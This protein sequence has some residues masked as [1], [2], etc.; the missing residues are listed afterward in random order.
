MTIVHSHVYKRVR[1]QTHK[2]QQNKDKKKWMPI[3]R[4]HIY[5]R[6]RHQ[7]NKKVALHLLTCML[8]GTP[9]YVYAANKRVVRRFFKVFLL[10]CELKSDSL[11]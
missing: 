2:K 10:V 7:T 4:S 3:L 6:V 11:F 8:Q 1:R 5:S 9:G